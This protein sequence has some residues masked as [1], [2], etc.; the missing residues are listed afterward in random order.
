[1]DYIENGHGLDELDSLNTLSM[2]Y[3]RTL[4]PSDHASPLG[5]CSFVWHTN[6]PLHELQVEKVD[7]MMLDEASA[8]HRPHMLEAYRD[9]PRATA[10]RLYSHSVKMHTSI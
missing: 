6:R 5:K 3:L 8:L 10:F 4:I 9:W 1:M 7:V 2:S